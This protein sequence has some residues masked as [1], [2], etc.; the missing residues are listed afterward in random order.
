MMDSA[1]NRSALRLVRQAASAATLRALW[2]VPAPPPVRAST[3]PACGNSY[4]RTRLAPSERSRA[5]ICARAPDANALE[6][7]TAIIPDA[8][9]G[10]S[11]CPRGAKRRS[12]ARDALAT[13]VDA[14]ALEGQTK[15]LALPLGTGVGLDRVTGVPP[16]PLQAE[17]SIA[18]RASVA[19]PRL[20][21]VSIMLASSQSSAAPVTS[22]FQRTRCRSLSESP[23]TFI[24]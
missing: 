20:P 16:P 24:S 9:A 14:A 7:D 4:S 21:K 22:A 23:V 12:A 2:P 3:S 5:A 1:S 17:S 19:V 11:P 13:A 6:Y 18:L 10:R 15:A 8:G